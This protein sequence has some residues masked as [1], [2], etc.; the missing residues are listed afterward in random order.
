MSGAM[1]TFTAGRGRHA[2]TYVVLRRKLPVEYEQAGERRIAFWLRTNK[3]IAV[4][5]A[6]RQRGTK[7]FMFYETD[8]GNGRI[9][10]S[11]AQR[12]N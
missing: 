9:W 5:T 6:R 7:E 1:E 10:H 12:L 11:P 8:L 4:V 2:A 3:I